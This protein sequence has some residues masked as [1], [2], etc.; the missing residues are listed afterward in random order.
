MVFIVLGTNPLFRLDTKKIYHHNNK[1]HSILLVLFTVTTIHFIYRNYD[2][3][4]LENFLPE[5]AYKLRLS[6]ISISRY[7]VIEAVVRIGVVL[8]I[9]YLKQKKYY[10]TFLCI[11][12]Y[13]A[14]YVISV[15]KAPI[16]TLLIVLLI[17]YLQDNKLTKKSV[18]VCAFICVSLLLYYTYVTLGDTNFSRFPL[19]ISALFNRIFAAGE[20]I[21]FT[22]EHFYNSNNY[23]EGASLPKIL[24]ALNLNPNTISISLPSYIMMHRLGGVGGAN[25]T[26]Y[27][28]GF[29]NYGIGGDLLF[30]LI[31]LVFIYVL[32]N[33]SRSILGRNY[34]IYQWYISFLLIDLV[35]VDMW[36]VMNTMIIICI[37]LCSI[38]IFTHK[39]YS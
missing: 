37:V 10:K 8:S 33:I 35:H 2:L 28:E 39:R 30:V 32:L 25:C 7:W 34:Y 3:I 23:L 22:Y 29:A 9:V 18:A 1:F 12:A 13:T 20:I 38:H 6:A 27:S 24:G 4:T 14:F 5:N 17:V 21:V 26:F 31:F 36:G 19:L 16:L 15:Q 11:L